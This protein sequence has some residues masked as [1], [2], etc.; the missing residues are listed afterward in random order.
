MLKN[1]SV[2]IKWLLI[3][4]HFLP[5]IFVL[6]LFLFCY[7]LFLF[8]N[9]E[10]ITLYWALHAFSSKSNSILI[11][12]LLLNHGIIKVQP[13]YSGFN[14]PE[15]SSCQHVMS[16]LTS[17]NVSSSLNNVKWFI[18]QST[19][20]CRDW[21]IYRAN[22]TREADSGLTQRFTAT[23]RPFEDLNPVSKEP[24]SLYHGIMTDRLLGVSVFFA[25]LCASLMVGLDLVLE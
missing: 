23:N 21:F 2:R 9:K 18:Q 25:L 16:Q 19:S 6:I 17:T 15:V 8:F 13:F 11:N 5:L 24:I 10:L 7:F 12:T 4:V 14:C 1:K 3:Y 22:R 20:L